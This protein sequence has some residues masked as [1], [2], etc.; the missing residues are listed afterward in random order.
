[1]PMTQPE[2]AIRTVASGANADAIFSSDASKLY[3][4]SGNTL[5]V[6][7]TAT[8]NVLTSYTIGT[9]LGAL[10][11]SQGGRYLAIVEEQPAGGAGI[12]YRIDLT[13]GSV[14]TF[15]LSGVSALH[16]VAWLANGSVVVS[17][18]VSGPL[19]VVN[20][21]TGDYWEASGA[22]PAYSTIAV[23]ADATYF[24]AQSSGITWPLYTYDTEDGTG[25]QVYGNP[26]P[27]AGAS[28]PGPNTR[29]GAVSP[30]GGLVVQGKTMVVYNSDLSTNI[31]LGS[32]YP[33]LRDAAAVSFS[34]DGTKLFVL[35]AGSD[36]VAVIRTSDW[37]IDATYPVGAYAFH[38]S[39]WPTGTQPLPGEMMRV[40]DDGDF[41]SIITPT[42]I[43]LINLDLVIEPSN[44]GPDVITGGS[45]VDVLVGGA[46]ADTI[47]GLDGDDVLY[48]HNDDGL[49][50]NDDMT[51]F[52]TLAEHDVING[53]AG[54]D[55]I[56]AGYG[57]DV[58]GGANGP[59]GD[60]LFISFLGASSGV[61]VDF[62]LASQTVGGGTITGI[63]N[64]HWVQ[65][66]NFDDTIN[67]ADSAVIF[68][69]GTVL[70]MGGSDHLIA[71]S[72]THM[73]DGGDGDDVVD[74]RPGEG[75]SELRGGAGNDTIYTNLGTSI[76][77]AYGDAGND[78][79][80]A[81]VGAYGGSGNDTIYA[82]GYPYSS[83]Y[84]YHGDE[85][86][87]TIV[88]SSENDGIWGGSGADIL[89]GGA[90]NDGIGSAGIFVSG[91]DPIYDDMGLEHDVLSGGD[92][93]DAFRA[94]Y[95]D[96]VDG[97]DGDDYLY[98]SLGGATTG[99]VID[100]AMFESGDPLIIAGGTI[101]NVERIENLR[102]TEFDDNLVIGDHG[103][104]SSFHLGA[105]DDL[106]SSLHGGPS[107]YGGDGNDRL[108]TGA[109]YGQ[110]GNLFDGAA[111]IDAVDY[112][113][114][115]GSVFLQLNEEGNG[116]AADNYG[117]VLMNV[118]N[119]LGSSF[120]DVFWGN[121]RNN[122]LVGGAGN[123][124]LD[125]GVGNDE[126]QGGAGIDTAEY[127]NA[128][129][130]VM[131]DLRLTTAQNT[132][133]SGI[134]TISGIED[135]W[136]S[137]F[138]DTFTGNSAANRLW[139]NGGN[140]TI[141]GGDG[142][143]RLD[144]GGGNDSLSGGNAHDHLHGGEGDD[145]LLGGAGDDNLEG[146]AG[147]DTL[148]GGAGANDLV[149]YS[150]NGGAVTVNLSLAGAQAIGGSAGTDTLANIEHVEGSSYA[151]LIIGNWDANWLYGGWDADVINGAGGDD[152]VYG[153]EGNDRLDGG[154]GADRLYGGTG[155][156][157]YLIENVLDI[158]SEYVGEGSDLVNSSVSYALR[159]NIE[160]LTLIGS[161]AIDGTGNGLDN[162]L[163]GNGAANLL[164][165]SSGEDWLLGNAGNDTLIG[166]SGNDV[167]NGGTGAD[168]MTG[169]FNSD[170]Y[171]VDAVSDVVAE[172]AGEGTD[173]VVST[174]DYTLGDNVENLTFL[175]VAVNGT[176]NA[177]N[178]TIRGSNVA[179]V[180]DGAAGADHLLG[181]A[182][183]DFYIVD[184]A[185]DRVSETT[186]FG[187]DTVQ[188]SV[189]FKLGA[190]VEHLTLTGSSQINGTGN[191]LNN[192]LIGND[193]VNSLH[194]QTGNDT[195]SGNGG[196]DILNG[197]GGADGLSGGTGDDTY[198]VDNAGDVV[199]E[200]AGEG[201][202]TVKAGVDWTLG[203]NQEQLNLTGSAAIDASGNELANV[204]RGN[205]GGNQIDGAAGNDTIFGNSGNDTL[206]GG[207]ARDTLVGGAG[208][209][210]FL[211]RDGDFGGATTGTADRIADFAD[212]DTIDLSLV[213]A[214]GTLA[215]DQAFAF[216]GTDAFTGA[217]GQ[218][219]FEQIGDSTF[220]QGDV[221][222][223]G[224]AD[225]MIRLN[226]LHT[227]EASDLLI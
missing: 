112:A 76:C 38:P 213:D 33:H 159:S 19:R 53:G 23:S 211:F 137:S 91:M 45:G 190:N 149:D 202:D 94:G 41:L 158:I 104:Y 122:L 163:R 34:P 105:G 191:G 205:G 99:V 37:E 82:Y 148:D 162:Y 30:D 192:T 180:L 126:L 178:N 106:V 203:A 12:L 71:G 121:S 167:L 186:D 27:Y 25:R 56:Y 3:S 11:I 124:R 131:V 1:M 119:V 14:S 79:I 171:Y 207:A 93:N 127:L 134:D 197:G 154:T 96:D 176:G 150:D 170:T 216:I 63:E 184:N 84:G 212:G 187:T 181:L 155:N 217:A 135:I 139:G 21:E 173:T 47:S 209:D 168:I 136:G 83:P 80:H 185:G 172:N 40:S 98:L 107:I 146:G 133:G 151:D 49:P 15:S 116:I 208:D 103:Y 100:T 57:D 85:G 9:K 204:I 210:I 226:G 48:S 108:I 215:G 61:T 16:D 160:D 65:G 54:S 123:D 20:L 166:G 102:L 6:I 44:V 227:L 2:G 28:V 132:G 183:N 219:R 196:D 43:Q 143:D 81:Y 147:N 198:Y 74:G 117:N 220:A 24:M 223:D 214:N 35:V 218:L 51:S 66:S 129:A 141:S 118:E 89:S 17:Q 64:V 46:G 68:T 5:S 222:G 157:I 70:G 156:D 128:A 58:D 52:D 87:D 224:T 175:G 221:D 101:Q 7:D 4:V 86:D 225:F 125:G 152:R 195:L 69:A 42:G 72:R 182:G 153:G 169:G 32:K 120:D 189:S 142:D 161:A 115:S 75:V 18:E 201:L 179:N 88:G 113:N 199:T 138:A 130:G 140:D 50:N 39:E 200:N 73:M 62:S 164:D 177:L 77:M 194:G 78:I 31:S 90:G 95:G 60:S 13:N 111:G 114:A 10:D 59:G 8:G 97:G 206:I 193:A 165:G 174:I 26:D 55:K 22:M 145:T 188:S 109:A 92:G 144:G 67:A 36:E 29:V 110:S